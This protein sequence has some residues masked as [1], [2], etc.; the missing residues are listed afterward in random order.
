MKQ[1]IRLNESELKHMIRE[2]VKKVLNEV[3]DNDIVTMPNGKGD[4]T[5]LDPQEKANRI[6]QD[7]KRLNFEERG[8]EIEAYLDDEPIEI[9]VSNINVPM[10]SDCQSI[11]DKYGVEFY[12]ERS[13]G[14]GIFEI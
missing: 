11:A 14:M 13:F 4:L 5:S 12:V 10:Q 3:F 9:S 7:L 8:H 6:I 1:T 2:S